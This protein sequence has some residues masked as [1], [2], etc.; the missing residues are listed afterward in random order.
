MVV[1][2]TPGVSAVAVA[3]TRASAHPSAVAARLNVCFLIGIL[4]GLLESWRGRAGRRS[5]DA[6]QRA[7][8]PVHRS[9]EGETESRA[10]RRH[11]VQREPLSE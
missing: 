4:L 8:L 7:L 5:R 10:G 9:S 2:V 6:G 1:S 11:A 3:A